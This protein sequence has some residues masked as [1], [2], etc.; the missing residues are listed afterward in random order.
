MKLENFISVV[1]IMGVP[2]ILQRRNPPYICTYAPGNYCERYG[3]SSF[4]LILLVIPGSESVSR[5]FAR[6]RREEAEGEIDGKGG[7]EKE[8]E[9][10]VS[11]RGKR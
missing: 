1:D 9:V 4:G 11:A 5:R 6:K 3:I 10:K 2:F 8:R 7:R